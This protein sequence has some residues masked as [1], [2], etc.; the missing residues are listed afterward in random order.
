MTDSITVSKFLHTLAHTTT[1]PLLDGCSD[2]CGWIAAGISLLAYGTY[3]VPIKE[4]KHL[5]QL[6][7]LV[8]QSYKTCTMLVLAP[9][10]VTILDGSGAPWRYSPWGLLSG[11][12]WVLGG[13]GGVVAVRW[14]GMA[15]AVG[16]WAS[17]M[18][19]VN[20]VWGLLIFEEPVAS[21]PETVAAF[22][23][24]TLG[25][26]GMS[27]F[28]VPTPIMATTSSANSTS[29][30]SSSDIRYAPAVLAKEE[31]FKTVATEESSLLAVETKKTHDNGASHS[32]VATTATHVYIGGGP[33][34]V[35][36]CK[37][38]LPK[39]TA[40]ILAAVFNGL[41]SGSCLIPMHY[42]AKHHGLGGAHYMISYAS[43]A[44]AANVVLWLLY[45]LVLVVLEMLLSFDNASTA[46]TSS[47]PKNVWQRAMADM[48]SFYVSQLWRPGFAAGTW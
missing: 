39:R 47:S 30:S 48:P 5:P 6:N 23:L 34:H 24:L 31:T 12:L 43:G 41:M 32:F 19:C 13:T 27:K 3:G 40:G 45:Y 46:I 18:I 17:V 14:C 36:G 22:G 33:Y 26:I 10:V 38:V 9:I 2:K 20:F 28:G 29:T 44:A 37:V 25:L 4:T 16:T 8:F 15:M 21:L 42:A 7:P 11:L 1:T 35:C